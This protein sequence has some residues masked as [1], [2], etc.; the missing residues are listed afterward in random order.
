[1][2]KRNNLTDFL[3]SEA[4]KFRS[5]LGTSQSINPQ[6]FDDLIDDV[7]DKGLSDGGV[8]RKD[9]NF[10][11]YDGTLLYSY[12]IA[13]ARTLSSLPASPT[14][15]G[16]ISQ[17]WNWTLSAIKSVNY[18]IEV[19]ALYEVS[20]S[21]VNIY[22]NIEQ[23]IEKNVTIHFRQRY[24]N[25]I[26]IDWGDGSATETS[27]SETGTTNLT[28]SHNY[29][30]TGKYV[31]KMVSR[32]GS[33]LILGNNSTTQN[34]VGG[35]TTNQ[36]ASNIVYK[37]ECGTSLHEINAY[38]FQ[39]L[40]NLETLIIA[41]QSITTLNSYTLRYCRKLKHVNIPSSI[42]LINNYC[43]QYCIN[44]SGISFPSTLDK[45][46]T[47]SCQF[48]TSL[49]YLSLPPNLSTLGTYTFQGCQSIKKITI[50]NTITAI[51]SYVFNNC[52]TLENVDYGSNI[53]NISTYAFQNCYLL[54]KITLPSSIATIGNSAFYLCTC[55]KE[56]IFPSTVTTISANAFYNCLGMCKYDFSKHT[57]VP[58]LSNKNAF[59]N[60]PTS[61]KIIVPDSLYDAWI[62]ATN[63][64]N[65]TNNIVKVSEV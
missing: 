33:G 43:F 63:W 41:D 54:E 55:L 65:F 28:F 5:I 30:S 49:R 3:T 11:D 13:E 48:C 4:N 20:G 10:V 39:Y 7:Y 64:T 57:S 9:I 38:A 12:T 58:T 61:C 2:S 56:V 46:Q 27:T 60:I 31:I 59:N 52:T 8:E 16:L 37:I 29:S 17:G 22:I 51:N 26:I 42:T 36:T 32:N 19:G 34:F 62:S 18:P 15:S 35:T 53:T 45:L 44:L 24:A 6:D 23:N 40:S 50:P 1:M 21:S 14:H 47:Y 25:D